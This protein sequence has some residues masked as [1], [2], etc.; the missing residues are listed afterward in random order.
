MI[1]KIKNI[2]LDIDNISKYVESLTEIKDIKI[3]IIPIF[4]NITNNF[5]KNISNC[6]DNLLLSKAWVGEIIE[7]LST[8]QKFEYK[9]TFW[10]AVLGEGYSYS[11]D[12]V[13]YKSDVNFLIIESNKQLTL[14]EVYDRLR[15][16]KGIKNVEG[17]FLTT[18]NNIENIIPEINTVFVLSDAFLNKTYIEK[19][20]FIIENVKELIAINIEISNSEENIQTIMLY[21]L[22]VKK[23]LIESKFNLEF[24]LQ[25]Q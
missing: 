20:N 12:N 16:T 25:K 2:I 18:S 4:N 15:N 10:D 19:I 8:S 21:W 22:Y 1:N 14:D 3:D 17:E 24:E 13:M 11:L 5:T 23:H 7:L 9:V 6:Y